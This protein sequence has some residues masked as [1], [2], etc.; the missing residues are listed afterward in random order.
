MVQ[1]AGNIQANTLDG[2]QI[3][4][5]ARV[6]FEI[7]DGNEVYTPLAPKGKVFIGSVML[8]AAIIYCAVAY[9]LF[10]LFFICH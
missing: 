8:A 3:L 6:H 5:M 7:R 4:T 10:K 1:Q 9:G 2:T